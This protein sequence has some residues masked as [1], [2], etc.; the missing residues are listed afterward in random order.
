[1][2]VRFFFLVYSDRGRKLTQ[3][4]KVDDSRRAAG[5]LVYCSII[6]WKSARP[7]DGVAD[8]L[9]RQT[10]IREVGVVRGEVRHKNEQV[11]DTFAA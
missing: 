6:K 10:C 11:N 7:G 9:R 1:M 2:A 8:P 5:I 4:T 3:V